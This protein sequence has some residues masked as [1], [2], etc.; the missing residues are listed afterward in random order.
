MSY[1]SLNNFSLY[2]FLIRSR[3][4]SQCIKCKTSF[5]LNLKDRVTLKTTSCKEYIVTKERDMTYIYILFNNIYVK[6]YLKSIIKIIIYKLK[7]ASCTMKKHLRV[8][9]KGLEIF[10]VCKKHQERPQPLIQ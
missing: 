1:Q 4:I 5:D 3:K 9:L 10:T 2:F 8:F 7:S 6:K